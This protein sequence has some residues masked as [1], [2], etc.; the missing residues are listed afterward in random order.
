M[1]QVPVYGDAIIVATSSLK[2]RQLYNLL[3]YEMLQQW[4]VPLSSDAFT[5]FQIE[6]ENKRQ[7]EANLQE[8][9]DYLKQKLIP[10]FA[11]LLLNEEIKVYD[12]PTLTLELHGIGINIRF[13]GLLRPYLKN[14]SLIKTVRAPISN[15][16]IPLR[17][18]S[19]RAWCSLK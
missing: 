5:M 9:E 13:L 10:Y 18:P 17:A 16:Y 15:S 14:V 6:D 2:G 12:G 7:D 3:R 19:T 4:K 1:A 8:V 11:D